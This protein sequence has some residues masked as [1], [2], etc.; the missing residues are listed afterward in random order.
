[1]CF[2]PV[3]TKLH[4]RPPRA[5]SA[6]NL[7]RERHPD[8]AA[9]FPRRARSYRHPMLHSRPEP[10][11]Q[12]QRRHTSPLAS[13][14]PQY[15][16]RRLT[17][18]AIQG[19]INL[20]NRYP[21]RYECSRRANPPADRLQYHVFLRAIEARIST[22]HTP[23]PNHELHQATVPSKIGLQDGASRRA[24]EARLQHAPAAPLRFPDPGHSPHSIGHRSQLA[25]APLFLSGFP[26]FPFASI[27]RLRCSRNRP[28]SRYP[29]TPPV[30]SSPRP[31][32]PKVFLPNSTTLELDRIGV[33]LPPAASPA[34]PGNLQHAATSWHGEQR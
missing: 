28:W 23:S 15:A 19:R 17:P 32:A 18:I 13:P 31:R 26:S 2:Q 16:L 7:E 25:T 12:R 20:I 33:R 29:R 6:H 24:N 8:L 5:Y 22:P 1:M 21:P 10:D 34:R 11:R 3:S 14:N 4:L 30:Q 27:H 9:R